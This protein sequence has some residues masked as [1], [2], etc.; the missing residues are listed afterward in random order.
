MLTTLRTESL[1]TFLLQMYISKDIQ[2]STVKF[3]YSQSSISE[4]CASADLTNHRSKIFEKKL[5]ESSQR[6][7]APL[8]LS[9]LPCRERAQGRGEDL[10]GLWLL[11]A[12]AL[13]CG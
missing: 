13:R 6:H 11:P 7:P 3:E 10:Q 4:G 12:L 8:P 2:L 5:P 9:L 1:N